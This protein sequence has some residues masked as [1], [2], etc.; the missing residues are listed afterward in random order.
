MFI[1]IKETSQINT[2]KNKKTLFLLSFLKDDENIMKHNTFLGVF[3]ILIIFIFIQIFISLIREKD[4]IYQ[5][6]ITERKKLMQFA[7]TILQSADFN[8]FNSHKKN[9]VLTMAKSSD[10]VFC[11]IVNPEGQ[12]YLSNIEDEQGKYVDKK[13]INNHD[14]IIVKDKWNHEN[15]E[16]MITPTYRNHTLWLGYNSNIINSVISQMIINQITTSFILIIV[17]VLAYILLVKSNKKLEK[18]GQHKS[19]IINFASKFIPNISNINNLLS[20]KTLYMTFVFLIIIICIQT[21]ININRDKN[22]R[23]HKVIDEKEKLANLAALSIENPYYQVTPAHKKEVIKALENFSDT[24]YCRIVNNK[25]IIYMSTIPNEVGKIINHYA[26]NTNKT[27]TIND[28][29]NDKSIKV[30][31]APTYRGYTLWLGYN[32]DKVLSQLNEMVFQY[33]K[34]TFIILMILLVYIIYMS[35]QISNFINEETENKSNLSS[36]LNAPK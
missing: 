4:E 16:I 17:C 21:Y 28:S 19:H 31:V 24:E 14:T 15:I 29:W 18:P 26:V 36:I 10:V 3:I 13:L 35:E 8:F 5:K 7:S 9:I 27:L 34:L 32:V 30:V 2:K 1:K 25:G 20:I 6:I 23:L 33:I 22:L 11:R 12:I